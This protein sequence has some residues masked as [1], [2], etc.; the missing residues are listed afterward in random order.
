VNPVVSGV[1]ARVVRELP[2]PD[3]P[4]FVH[5]EWTANMPWLAQGITGS[6]R[7]SEDMSWFGATPVG[8]AQRRWREVRDAMGCVTSVHAR[9]VHGARVLWHADLNEGV[10]VAF[11]ADGHATSAA[12]YLLTVSVADCVPVLLVDPKRRAV[13]AL[14]AGWRGVAAGVLEAGLET[15]RT[16]AGCNVRDVLVHFG[17]AICGEC[18][19]VGP[20]VPEALGLGNPGV[21]VQ[22]DVR[23]VLTERAVKSD[24]A[25]E[26][27]TCSAWCT[28]CGDSPFF[29]HR[30]GQAER[31]MAVI[32]IRP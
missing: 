25:Y 6:P 12:R 21:K 5:P 13:A 29:S 8:E 30:A 9:Q 4:L 23:G 24:V 15:I 2:L 32:G 16:Q 26:N 10:V 14:H 27:I 18:Y 31:Q 1:V 11:D 28:K 19:E 7:G 3:A 17:P 20:E 22:L